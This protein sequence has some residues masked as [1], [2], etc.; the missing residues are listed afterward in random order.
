MLFLNK[1][2]TDPCSDHMDHLQVSMPLV[3][4][5]FHLT[6]Y[7]GLIQWINEMNCDT[8]MII[9]IDLLE[10]EGCQPFVGDPSSLLTLLGND[11]LTCLNCF[12]VEVT[13]I[14]S[15]CFPRVAPPFCGLLWLGECLLVDPL[16]D[17][18]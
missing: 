5:V 18:Q 10:L 9:L 16:L 8:V 17:F 3:T 7:F 4:C 13:L 2:S 1:A 15:S 14:A 12:R 6:A 11:I